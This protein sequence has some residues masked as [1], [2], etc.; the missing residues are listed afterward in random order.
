MEPLWSPVVATG[1]NH[2]QIDLGAEAAETSQKPLPWVA[3]GRM[4]RSMVSRASA[5]GCH[6]LRE[7][8]SL[9]GRRS[10]SLK[11]QVPRTRRPTGLD[12][13]TLTAQNAAVKHPTGGSPRTGLASLAEFAKLRSAVG[14]DRRRRVLRVGRGRAEDRAMTAEHPLRRGDRLARSGPRPR[15]SAAGVRAGTTK[16]ESASPGQWTAPR[17]RA[18]GATGA[19]RGGTSSAHRAASWSPAAGRRGRS[20]RRSESPPRARRRTA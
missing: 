16:R 2:W 4:R 11:R 18:A 10:T 14:A 15:R 7:V 6:P 1:R 5:V 19:S 3:T 9:R 20:W 13:A 8:P 17:A 12:R